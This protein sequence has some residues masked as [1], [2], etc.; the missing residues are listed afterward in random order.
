MRKNIVTINI[1]LG[2]VALAFCSGVMGATV[3][4]NG[5]STPDVVASAGNTALNI[6]SNC[7]LTSSL[8]NSYVRITADTAP[9]TVTL[10]NNVLV[11]T[12]STVNTL[13][14]EPTGANITFNLNYSLTFAGVAGGAPLLIAARG[15]HNVI[16]NINGGNS[17]TLGSSGFGGVAFYVIM[18]GTVVQFNRAT[19]DVNDI[20]INLLSGSTFGYTTNQPL[21]TASTGTIEFNPTNASTG[22]MALSIADQ[23]S[24]LLVVACL[25]I[26]HLH[27]L[28]FLRISIPRPLPGV[29][30]Y[31]VS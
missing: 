12:S 5:T 27:T 7:S 14:L 19:T 20:F 29:R 15:G 22:H 30:L 10:S 6:Q 16:F 3:L 11:G 28:S 4:W 25:T 26:V 17:F 9:I 13:F 18:D 21:G 2:A 24:V 8:G 31:L 23:A 1:I